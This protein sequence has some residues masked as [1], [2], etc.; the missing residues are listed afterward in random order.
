MNKVLGL[1]LELNPFHN[2][3]SFFIQEAKRKVEPDLTIAIVTTNFSM[4]G[5]IQVINKFEKTKLLLKDYVDIVLELPY[6]G[7]V[8]S[9][10]YF[11][12]NSVKSLV[13][14]GITDLAFGVETV[15]L[16]NLN[17]FCSLNRSD[18]YNLLI[19][20][21]LNKGFSY[22]TSSVKAI[23]QITNDNELAEQFSLPNNT[24]AIQYLNALEK[25]NS[26]V[27]VTLIKRISNNYYDE[28]A[29]CSVAS[30]TSLRKLLQDNYPIDE[31]VPDIFKDSHYIN[32]KKAENNLY[33]LIQYKLTFTDN[34]KLNNILG[35]NEG[36]ENR[37]L[38]F[39]NKDNYFTFIE[40][41]ETKR[42]TKSYLKRLMIHLLLDVPKTLVPQYY[43]YLRVLGMNKK[44]KLFISKLKKEIKKSII[45]SFKNHEDDINVRYELLATKLY[46]IITEQND[47]YLNEY[48]IPIILGEQK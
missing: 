28:V 29:T 46:S 36:I 47:L 39:I 1:I 14:L 12:Y 2:G 19:K 6:L 33:K 9:A 23:Q 22:S 34:E 18:E 20:E 15:D 42:Y 31:Y 17:Y 37:L 8:C 11:A 13:E 35:M 45:T 7:A 10:D 44:G 38:S 43:N 48:K 24:L 30:A 21:Y 25:L 5:D 26:N 32:I 3:H 27:T 41:I 40:S 4:R 16:K